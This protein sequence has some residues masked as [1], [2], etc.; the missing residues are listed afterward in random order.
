MEFQIVHNPEDVYAY[1]AEI[2]ILLQ[3]VVDYWKKGW[4][5]DPDSPMEGDDV[6]ILVENIRNAININEGN[7]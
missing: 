6:D 3:P 1:F 2:I 5:H 7:V 4:L